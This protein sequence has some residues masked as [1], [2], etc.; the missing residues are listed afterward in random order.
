[1]IHALTEP[2]ASEQFAGAADAL[3]VAAREFV[4]EQNVL[5]GGE[6]GDELVALK[7]EA[8]LAAADFGEFVFFEVGDVDAIKDD[9]TFARG[10]EAGE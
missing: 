6:G 7:D 8:D 9:G 4:R 2:D 1:M 5:F 10:V 3:D